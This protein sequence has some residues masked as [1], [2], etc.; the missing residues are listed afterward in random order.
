MTPQAMLLAYERM[1]ANVDGFD[2]R[3]RTVLA[4]HAAIE[5]ELD[6]ALAASVPNSKALKRLGFGQKVSVWSALQPGDP[7]HIER[8]AAP[9]LRFN[10]LR[11]CVAHGD[12]KRK[13]EGCVRSLVASVPGAASEDASLQL[14]VAAGFVFGALHVREEEEGG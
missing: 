6:F 10:D 14:W 9:M 7:A 5:R 12:S 1:R 3:A 2:E 4:M 8:L 13:L 11:N